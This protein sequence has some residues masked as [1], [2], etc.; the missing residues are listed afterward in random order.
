MTSSIVVDI[1]QHFGGIRF[2]H[3]EARRIE[4]EAEIF[5]V[6]LVSTQVH[7]VTSQKAVIVVVTA[8]RNLNLVLNFFCLSP[9]E[10]RLADEAPLNAK[11]VIMSCLRSHVVHL[12]DDRSLLARQHPRDDHKK[13]SS[14][15]Q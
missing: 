8:V 2:Q 6:T 15:S 4:M 1:H 13:N 10:H 14:D 12:K 3:L 11:N 9:F 5:S 7:G